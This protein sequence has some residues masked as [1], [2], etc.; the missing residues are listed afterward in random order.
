MN[1][2]HFEKDYQGKNY[3]ALYIIGAIMEG[4][5]CVGQNHSKAS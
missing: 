2:T 5:N 1:V 3:K 4:L